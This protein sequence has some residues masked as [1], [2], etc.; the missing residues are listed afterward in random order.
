[1]PPVIVWLNP[2]P[3]AVIDTTVVLEATATD[4]QG[5]WRVVFYIAG[6]EFP[7]A[8]VDSARGLYHCL[9][10]AR[11]YPAGPYPLQARAWDAARNVASTPVCMV[12]VNH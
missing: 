1:M 9:W 5:I 11:Y 7:G 12:S 6:F 3:N 8:L 2:S 4:N 10:N